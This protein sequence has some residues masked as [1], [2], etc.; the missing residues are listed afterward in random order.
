MTGRLGTQ[1]RLFESCKDSCLNSNFP[2]LIGQGQ[3]STACERIDFVNGTQWL[4]RLVREGNDDDDFGAAPDIED[5]SGAVVI[6]GDDDCPNDEEAVG[7]TK[8]RVNLC[9]ANANDEKHYDSNDNCRK[10][11]RQDR[12]KGTLRPC[13]CKR[14]LK[15]P[16]SRN[17]DLIRE[18]PLWVLIVEGRSE[19][20]QVDTE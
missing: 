12:S 8:K 11:L 3:Y 9:V 19:S 6:D 5:G 20:R 17:S 2:G 7:T 4:D 16:S 14:R 10:T 18:L 13:S 15:L 1:V